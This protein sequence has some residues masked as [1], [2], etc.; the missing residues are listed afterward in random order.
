MDNNTILTP[1]KKK[2][3][4]R[5]QRIE[6]AVA[7]KEPDK[8]PLAPSFDGVIQNF[9]GSSYKNTYYDHPKAIDAIVRFYTDYPQC[10]ATMTNLLIS[11]KACELSGFNFIDWPGRPGTSVSDYSTHQIIEHEYMAQEEYPELL[12]DFTGFMIRKYIPRAYDRLQGLQNFSFN[13]STVLSAAFLAPF[14]SPAMLDSYK[15]FA[16]IGKLEAETSAAFMNQIDQLAAIG[17]PSMFM[18]I[19][20]APYDI[21][22]DYFRGTVG[23]MEDLFEYEDEIKEA[24]DMFADQQIQA[25]QFLR[26]IPMKGKRVFFPLHKGMDGFMNDKQYEKLYWN[27]LKKIMLALIDMGVTPYVFAEGKYSTRLHYL[28]D[29]PKGK[30]IY[31][32]EDI[33]MREAKKILGKVACISGNLPVAL[34]E[35]GK[36]ETIVNYCK[37]LI[38]N[39]AP[40]GG[41]IFD[42]NGACENAKRENINTMFEVFETYR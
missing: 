18:A 21:L 33:D 32:F 14:Y 10:D 41:Y 30:V 1:E 37:S 27:P 2:Y 4:E 20:E 31:H 17:M 26:F 15:L 16:E 13:T 12:K 3:N 24:C 40:G 36:K 29:V 6:D 19:S 35:Y 9:Y 22:G 7:L 42:F 34:M 39:C 38:D 28:A 5:L 25:L 8:I 23:I 11:G